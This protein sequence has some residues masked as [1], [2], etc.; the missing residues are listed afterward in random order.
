MKTLVQHINEAL[1]VEV[2][3][4]NGSK[5]VVISEKDFKKLSKGHEVTEPF[6][7][8]RVKILDGNENVH[9]NVVLKG[10]KIIATEMTEEEKRWYCP[11]VYKYIEGK[12]VFML[13]AADKNNDALFIPTHA[14]MNPLPKSG[15]DPYKNEWGMC[16]VGSNTGTAAHCFTNKDLDKVFKMYE[17][18]G[19]E[20]IVDTSDIQ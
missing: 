9:Y 8:K 1:G 5:T 18:M 11:S 19:Y 12:P 4:R 3:L 6:P 10:D 17:K 16:P 15:E 2:K 7:N 13:H 20:V 14:L